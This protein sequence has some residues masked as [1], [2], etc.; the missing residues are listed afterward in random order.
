MLAVFQAQVVGSVHELLLERKQPRFCFFP[1]KSSLCQAVHLNQRCHG[2][3]I[4]HFKKYNHYFYFLLLVQFSFS[5]FPEWV[6]LFQFSSYC[7][8]M[9]RFTLIFI[10]FSVLV[11]FFFF[12]LNKLIHQS[13]VS[14]VMIDFAKLINKTVFYLF[15]L[16]HKIFFFPQYCFSFQFLFTITTIILTSLR[17]QTVFI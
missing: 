6:C 16:A 14:Q 7:L 12:S 17:I 1:L 3:Y 4:F 9:F 2:G 15:C 10:S 8:K 5:E 11:F 13:L